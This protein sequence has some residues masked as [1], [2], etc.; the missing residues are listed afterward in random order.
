MQQAQAIGT[1][2]A[3]SGYQ[4]PTT[5]AE[6]EVEFA[7]RAVQ[8]RSGITGVLSH[9]IR[10][11]GHG[12]IL[13][14]ATYGLMYYLNILPCEAGPK[15][16]LTAV[17]LGTTVGYIIERKSAAALH[18]DT[19]TPLAIAKREEKKLSGVIQ[20]LE[21]AQSKIRGGE[22]P[23]ISTQS[24]KECGLSE[25]AERIQKSCTQCSE[26]TI[27]S[28]TLAKDLGSLIPDRSE[29]S[30]FLTSYQQD[31]EKTQESLE[32]LGSDSQAV[33]T[34]KRCINNR[35]LAEK[36][37]KSADKE[38]M[39]CDLTEGITKKKAELKALREKIAVLEA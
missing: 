33:A 7:G 22:K 23:I 9:A 10:G 31:I 28:T 5:K 38:L 8:Y 27:T 25:Q 3:V 12:A 34:A 29:R 19:Q 32:I 13:G 18:A 15:S 24:L 14:A 2:P 17:S 30:A 26:Y 20:Y 16:F 21:D 11:G 1:T 4:A 36:A 35:F 37:Q 39:K 6:I